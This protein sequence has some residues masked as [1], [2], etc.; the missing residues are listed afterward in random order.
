MARL[1][2]DYKERIVPEMKK[3]FSVNNTLAI[4]KLQKICI[5]MG[6]GKALENAKVLDEA[7]RD[8]TNIT[9]QKAVLTKAKIAVSAFKVRSG[10]RVGWRVTLRGNK[11]YEFLDRLISVS[12][13]RIKDFRGLKETSFDAGGGYS[14]GLTEQA[15]WPEINMANATFVHGMHINIVFTGS[16]REMSTFALKELGMPF[17]RAEEEK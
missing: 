11:M 8:L 16:N 14:M 2:A 9:G 12:I 5:N 7:V 10:N 1:L 17:V 3:T 15:V 13:P 6:L 4:P